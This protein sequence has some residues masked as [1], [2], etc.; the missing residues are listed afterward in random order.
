MYMGEAADKLHQRMT[1]RG[2]RRN[3]LPKI[4]TKECQGRL[5]GILDLVPSFIVG[6]LLPHVCMHHQQYS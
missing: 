6:M 3:L 4:F 5:L 1:P 2:Q